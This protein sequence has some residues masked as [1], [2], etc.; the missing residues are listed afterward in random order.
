MS[1]ETVVSACANDVDDRLKEAR[2]RG[3][4]DLR[5]EAGP[6]GPDCAC[7]KPSTFQLRFVAP[8]VPA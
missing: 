5:C 7:G 6:G 3:A 1:G 8:E 2:A 4:F